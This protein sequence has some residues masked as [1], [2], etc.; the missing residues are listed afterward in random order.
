MKQKSDIV[1]FAFYCREQAKAIP[2]NRAVVYPTGRDRRGKMSYAHLTFARLD[3]DSD[4]Y[5]RGLVRSGITRGVKTVLM[6]KPSPEF[7]SLTLALFKVGA[8]PVVVDP[9]MG[10]RRM[11]RCIRETEPEAF[12]GIT[13]AHVVRVFCRGYF[14]GVT[15]WL[16]VG[17]RLFWGGPVLRDAYI[18]GTEPF[19]IAET[20]S[21]D[22]AA[23]VFTTGS[24]GPA[25]GAVYHHGIFTSQLALLRDNYNYTDGAVDLPTF[26]MFALFDAALGVTA[27]IP[28][29]DPTRPAEVRPLNIIEPIIE[30]GVTIMFASPA[31]LDTVA[32]Y[33]VR[34]GVKLPSLKQVISAGAPVSPAVIERFSAMLGDPSKIHT[35]YGATEALPITEINGKEILSETRMQTEQG[36]GT[37]VGKALHGLEIKII[38][39]T[40]DAIPRLTREVLAKQGEIGEIIVRGG[41]VS[42]EYY[43]R[44]EANAAS[45]IRDGNSF[46]HRMGDVGWMD[47]H[48]RVWFCGRKKHRVRTAAGTLYTLPVEAIFNTHPDVFRS[49]L[50]GVGKGEVQEPVIC[51]EL[52]PESRGKNKEKIREELLEIGS[53]FSHTKDISIILF[54]KKFPTDI[55][56]NAKI[57]REKLAIWGASKI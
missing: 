45:K 53:K 27:V 14:K 21:G 51:I 57:F 3:H 52:E 54:H 55:R 6:V 33:G 38:K 25:K 9:G 1:N 23:I 26:P 12:I 40:D 48:S 24:T 44:S 10:M 30:Q 5:A 11:L 56:H 36:L 47:A 35:P 50:V 39:I 2:H 22:M 8:V 19:P 4:C 41:N 37:C 32:R 46:W 28:D 18:E 20:K 7:F 31:L 17:R 43:R 49:A 16:T 34:E 29:M 15:K 13:L 42:R